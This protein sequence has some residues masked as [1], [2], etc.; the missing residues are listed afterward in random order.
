[1]VNRSSEKTNSGLPIPPLGS[2]T[3]D[4]KTSPAAPPPMV[5][6]F[7]SR[8]DLQRLRG[9]KIS[10]MTDEDLWRHHSYGYAFRK[11][12]L[13]EPANAGSWPLD[14]DG[15][16]FNV[17]MVQRAIAYYRKRFGKKTPV[18]H[19]SATSDG[20]VRTACRQITAHELTSAEAKLLE[21]E[22]SA[23]AA[24]ANHYIGVLASKAHRAYASSP[25]NYR[26]HPP[27]PEIAPPKGFETA[28]ISPD[29][30]SVV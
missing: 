21:P 9:L 16:W 8:D 7:P 20:A 29:R 27:A 1:M 18:F 5:T 28:K 23:L 24:K 2:T 22:V 12:L 10:A 14:R 30:K 25:D 26:A 19:P 15:V 11:V 17:E 4:G 3:D 13:D 6:T